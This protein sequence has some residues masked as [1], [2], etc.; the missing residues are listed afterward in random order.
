MLES[1]VEFNEKNPDIKLTGETNLKITE[2]E[3]IKRLK[4]NKE[5][6][7]YLTV[8][9]WESKILVRNGLFKSY[10]RGG[11]LFF[12]IPSWDNFISA[13]N[14]F[15]VSYEKDWSEDND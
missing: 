2:D 13:L 6:K 12:D 11:E 15:A 7:L 3:L 4:E 5:W 8:L 9:H 10:Y 14:A 1:L